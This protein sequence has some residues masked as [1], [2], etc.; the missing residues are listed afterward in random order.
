M[1]K[2]ISKG[3]LLSFVA[4]GLALLVNLVYT[5]FL[6]RI[7][8]Q[9]E[10]GLYQLVLS[11]VNYL[12]L[13]NFGFT[14]AYVSFYA[15]E[16]VKENGEKAVARLNGMFLRI[17]LAITLI[18]VI[19]GVFLFRHIQILG[20]QLTEADYA[21]ARQL[22]IYLVLN[23]AV[24]FPNSVFTV[25]IAARERFVFKQIITILNYVLIP[26]C[27]IPAL[28]LGW[29]SVGVA[30]VTLGLSV[31]RLLINM[32]YCLGPLKMK[33][34]FGSFDRILFFSLVGFT[35][36]I[37]LSDVVDQLNN[38]VDKFLLGRI[39]GTGAVAVYSVGFE[40]ATYYTACSWAISEMFV[41]EANRIVVEE[42]DDDKLTKLFTRIGRYNNYILLLIQTAFFLVGKDF[43]R[44]WAGEGYETSYWV[45]VILM[46]ARYIPA[47]Q[48]MGVNI[49]NAKDMHRP[50]S[51]IY[52]GIAIVNVAAS[53]FLIRLWGEIGTS[54]G[55]LA[56]VLLGTGLF[57]NYYYHRRIGLNVIYF[58]KALLRWTFMA[59]ALCGIVFLV[60]RFVSLDNWLK[61]FGFVAVYSILYLAVLWF[62]GM[63]K[64]ER[65]EL[66]DTISSLR[67]KRTEQF[68]E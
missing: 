43:I 48:T 30:A 15:R 23:L 38:N 55:T 58:W 13:M 56:A 37:F 25:Y 64:E 65:A 21:T 62:V 27:N 33:F 60:A 36:F 26:L 63:R 29:G 19:A 6:I 18:C 16:K 42:K 22:L 68:S 4:Q 12:N 10:Y 7:L 41:P 39:I 51:V 52:F 5:P 59:T 2:Q 1:N 28:Y 49:Q 53:I 67:G 14:G 9:N 40:L 66:Q 50:R 61:L 11:V 3:V 46:L 35:F 57:M 17:F 44:L 47:V 8:G 31:L 34:R 45:A 24:S 20:N 32:I 54:L